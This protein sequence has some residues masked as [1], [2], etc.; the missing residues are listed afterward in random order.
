M[1]QHRIRHLLIN[2]LQRPVDIALPLAFLI[3]NLFTHGCWVNQPCGSVKVNSSWLALM[4]S[5]ARDR[6]DDGWQK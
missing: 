2:A 4:S 3:N 6:H 1:R 5:L